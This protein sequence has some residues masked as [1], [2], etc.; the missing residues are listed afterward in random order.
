MTNNKLQM[1][2]KLKSIGYW[3]LDI[4]YWI[5]NEKGQALITL[6]FFSVIAITVTSAAVVILLTNSL[7]GAKLQQGTIAY[8]IA[9]AGIENATLR[10]LRDP[11]YTGESLSVGDGVATITVVRNGQLYTIQSKGIIGNF[12]RTVQAAATYSN[13]LLTVSL[14]EEVY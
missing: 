13:N 12:S 10:L 8:Q 3:L 9:Q 4:R 11:N 2:N 14:Q 1:S 6:L 7:S 5:L